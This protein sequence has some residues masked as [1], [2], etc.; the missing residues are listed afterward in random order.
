MK[1]NKWRATTKN[2]IVIKKKN[3]DNVTLNILLSQHSLLV[4]VWA[5]DA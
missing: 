3:A 1:A 2:G 4:E 5:C